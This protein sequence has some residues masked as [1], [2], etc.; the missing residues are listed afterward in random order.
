[1]GFDSSSFFKVSKADFAGFIL[2]LIQLS[3]IHL[4]YVAGSVY[5]AL[6]LIHVRNVSHGFNSVRKFKYLYTYTHEYK[7]LQN[8]LNCTVAC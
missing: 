4:P 3:L 1:M 5:K 6:K 8:F 2:I 7:I